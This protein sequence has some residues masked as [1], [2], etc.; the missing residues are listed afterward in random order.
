[1][2]L[3]TVTW[4]WGSGPGVAERVDGLL[5][6]FMVADGGVD[7][8]EVRGEEASELCEPRGVPLG[9]GSLMR[10]EEGLIDAGCLPA[11]IDVSWAGRWR[12]C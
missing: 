7:V 9:V 3:E 4:A 8:N 2:S 6:L 5:A 10:F 1:L 12:S 11:A